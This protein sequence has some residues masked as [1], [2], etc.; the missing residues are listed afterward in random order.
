MV[1]MNRLS[2]LFLL[3]AAATPAAFG[4]DL[5]G[6]PSEGTPHAGERLDF[7]VVWTGIEVGKLSMLDHGWVEEEA[8]RF[9]KITTYAKTDGKVKHLYD[10]RRQYISYLTP[11]HRPSRYE[12]WEKEKKDW[13]RKEW[14]SFE[15][16][17]NEIRRF[18][19]EKIRNI[20]PIQPH[21][22]DPITAGYRLRVHRLKPGDFVQCTVSLGKDVYRVTATVEKGEPL[23]TILGERE[24]LVISPKVYWKGELVG[25]RDFKL[26]LTDDDLQIPVKAFADIEYGSFTATLSEYDRTGAERS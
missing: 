12:E 26:W 6:I 7:T 24:T 17:R 18:K 9:H 11:D 23:P 15:F 10:S 16:D 14:L 1:R 22:L 20:L 25:K 3:F 8:G 4:R 13:E 19:H 5:S 21:Y 2:L